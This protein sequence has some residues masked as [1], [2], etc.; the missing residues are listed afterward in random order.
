[1][2]QEARPLVA[3]ATSVA[4]ARV[5]DYLGAGHRHVQPARPR[6][7]PR[8]PAQR[9][10]RAPERRATT[11]CSAANAL[12]RGLRAGERVGRRPRRR[13]RRAR[14]QLDRQ[15]RDRVARGGPRGCDLREP[16]Q[17]RGA[18]RV[19]GARR[20]PSRPATSSPRSRRASSPT[21]ART[22]T[23]DQLAALVDTVPGAA[24]AGVA[25]HR[26]RRVAGRGGRG[27]RVRAR[28]PAPVE[29]P[30]QGRLRQP[31]DLPRPH[32]TAFNAC[33]ETSVVATRRTRHTASEAQRRTVELDP[34]RAGCDRRPTSRSTRPSV[35]LATLT[36]GRRRRTSTS[37]P[38]ET[39]SSIASRQMLDDADRASRDRQRGLERG[40]P[41]MARSGLAS[42]PS[43]G[44]LPMRV[45]LA[46][47]RA[48]RQS[49]VD[50]VGESARVGTDE[51][52]RLVAGIEDRC[53]SI[54]QYGSAV[55]R[56]GRRAT[57]SS[58]HRQ[59]GRALIDTYRS[60][61]HPS[62]RRVAE[63]M[64][65][66]CEMGVHDDGRRQPAPEAG[67]REP[68]E[69]RQLTGRSRTP[70]EVLGVAQRTDRRARRA[71]ES[72]RRTPA[73]RQ[74]RSCHR[75]T[76]RRRQ[77]VEARDVARVTMS[78]KKKLRAGSLTSLASHDRGQPDVAD[79]PLP[80][81]L[82]HAGCSVSHRFTVVA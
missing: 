20:R 79:L 13:P 57:P 12:R 62:R 29:A 56:I 59:T 71:L 16:R 48:D 58:C 5:P 31:G 34:G 15:D 2:R 72:R 73:R 23:S 35:V 68:F 19:Q 74:T 82:S 8:Q 70:A 53:R 54:G 45:R 39:R 33:V 18:H 10:Q 61:R 80:A 32:V 49:G 47:R 41:V 50:P 65:S 21:P 36:A 42:Q 46:C 17:G 1:M 6:Q 67:R 52:A 51:V 24:G 78:G 3:S 69:P 75:S 66:S 43:D 76:P 44:R 22:V 64:W 77:P 4:G 60:T 55:R 37:M 26:R 63:P 7:Q 81:V 11:R 25:A 40:R 9:C 14:R 27:G 38:S 30:Q 28:R